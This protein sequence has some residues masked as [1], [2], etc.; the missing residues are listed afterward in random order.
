MTHRQ[1]DPTCGYDPY[2]VRAFGKLYEVVF[3]QGRLSMVAVHVARPGR[4]ER[5]RVIYYTADGAMPE[6]GRAAEVVACIFS[7]R[8][9]CRRDATVEDADQRRA[10]ITRENEAMAVR[11]VEI[12]VNERQR[13]SALVLRLL[14]T[15]GFDNEEQ[16]L[17][18]IYDAIKADGPRF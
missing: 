18:A 17:V 6:K 14:S 8:A 4:Y 3:S 1:P 15:G 12:E 5:P 7:E 10:R 9:R 2:F 16:R 11:K 13:K